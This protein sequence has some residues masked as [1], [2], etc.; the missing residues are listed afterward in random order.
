[1]ADFKVFYDEREDILCLTREG[2][3]EEV[4]ELSLE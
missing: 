4:V 2:L 1:M 3:E